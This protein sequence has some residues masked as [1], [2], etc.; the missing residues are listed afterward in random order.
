MAYLF[1]AL[2][3]VTVL[4]SFFNITI[5]MTV[6]IRYNSCN[7]MNIYSVEIFGKLYILVLFAKITIF[8][9]KKKV[10][11][12]VHDRR[13]L[14]LLN[15]CFVINIFHSYIVLSASEYSNFSINVI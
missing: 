10:Y 3:G 1:I 11:N 5:L 4:L 6:T 15:V 12:M 9:F 2:N 14:K 7:F 8:S 13:T